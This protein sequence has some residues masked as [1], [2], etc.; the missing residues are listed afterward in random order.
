METIAQTSAHARDLPTFGE[1][2]PMGLSFL[3]G[4]GRGSLRQ[5]PASDFLRAVAFLP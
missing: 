3:S 5:P 4:I 2:L 1:R